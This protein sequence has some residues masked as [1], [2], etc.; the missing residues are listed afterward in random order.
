[1]DLRPRV[2]RTSKPRAW[3][4]VNA[5]GVGWSR[6]APL[7]Q[8]VFMAPGSLPDCS[9]PVSRP[10]FPRPS[11]CKVLQALIRPVL[12]VMPVF[13]QVDS[14]VLS[15]CA[16][17]LPLREAWT[18]ARAFE[19]HRQESGASSAVAPG[20]VS[21]PFG[22]S[23]SSTS[24]LPTFPA[25]SSHPSLFS[26][27]AFLG[28]RGGPGFSLPHM[29]TALGGGGNP[30]A[31]DFTV[32]AVTFCPFSGCLLVGFDENC[33]AAWRISVSSALDTFVVLAPVRVKRCGSAFR[34]HSLRSRLRSHCL[35]PTD[36]SV[37][38]VSP[39][40][41][42]PLSRHPCMGLPGVLAC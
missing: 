36:L 35:F 38:H 17:T 29:R 31:G 11:G 30:T 8:T 7:P 5:V 19:K 34:S 18:A 10:L 3:A 9:V 24:S 23:A 1:M 41:F 28:V 6:A 15:H 2:R 4:R 20:A 26:A 33:V 16:C 25:S 12:A 40:S 13:L 39:F 21:P 22:Q 37:L 14:S 27:S 32:Q 42:V